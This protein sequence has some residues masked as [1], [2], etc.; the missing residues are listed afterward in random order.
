VRPRLGELKHLEVAVPSPHG[1][2]RVNATARSID[3]TVPCNTLAA[4]CIANLAHGPVPVLHLDGGVVA[5]ED[6]A[7]EGQ[8]ACVHRVGCGVGGAARRLA[9]V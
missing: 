2:I 7:L 8:H 4:L 5:K 3:V 1:A 9:W 6:M